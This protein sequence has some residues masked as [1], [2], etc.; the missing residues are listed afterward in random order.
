M[1]TMSQGPIAQHERE[2][3]PAAS[4][5]SLVENLPGEVEPVITTEQPN[6]WQWSES[7]INLR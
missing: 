5:Q 6:F 1:P 3:I 4:L 2:H 7:S